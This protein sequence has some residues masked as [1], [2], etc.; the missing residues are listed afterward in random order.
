M[1]LHLLLQFSLN[2]QVG[3]VAST[4][5]RI[6]EKPSYSGCRKLGARHENCPSRAVERDSTDIRRA[7][8][9]FLAKHPPNDDLVEDPCIGDEELARQLQEEEHSMAVFSAQPAQRPNVFEAVCAGAGRLLSNIIPSRGS[10]SLRRPIS[11]SSAAQGAPSPSLLPTTEFREQLG[12]YELAKRMQEQEW[13]GGGGG[14]GALPPVADGSASSPS[15]ARRR[16][17]SSGATPRLPPADEA[18][19][20]VRAAA[21]DGTATDGSG[22]AR[23]RARRPAGDRA[24]GAARGRRGAA[25]R[26]RRAGADARVRPRPRMPTL[27]SA[28]AGGRDWW[29]IW[30]GDRDRGR[31]GTHG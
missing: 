28:G 20:P 30:T 11:S 23:A 16:D 10:N 21:C 1:S 8:V 13:F 26:A 25:A 14:G 27:S 24:A 29:K 15:T 18:L 9:D 22:A 31:T 5:N 3:L 2:H 12:D 6:P 17:S 7:R 4:S 19:R